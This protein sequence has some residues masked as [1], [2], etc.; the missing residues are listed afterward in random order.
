M[1]PVFVSQGDRISLDAAVQT[2]LA[3]CC[4][5]RLPRASAARPSAGDE[6]A[7]S[8]PSLGR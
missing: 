6:D 7:A 2:I 4:G 3:T 8:R 1:T 5:Y